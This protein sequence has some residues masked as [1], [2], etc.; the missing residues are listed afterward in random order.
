MRTS[1]AI[2]T[3]FD[4]IARLSIPLIN[5]IAS[6]QEHH[7]EKKP[8]EDTPIPSLARTLGFRVW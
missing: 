8:G 7:V 1:I 6:P 2:Q 5:P 3:H 4:D